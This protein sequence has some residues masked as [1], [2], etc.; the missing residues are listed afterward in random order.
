MA[1]SSPTAFGARKRREFKLLATVH[2]VIFDIL[3]SALMQKPSPED[4]RGL[5]AGH[6]LI[7]DSQVFFSIGQTLLSS[8]MKAS[9]AGMVATRL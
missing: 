4:G 6:P 9:F 7:E 5:S 2:G 8:G 1:Q 3:C